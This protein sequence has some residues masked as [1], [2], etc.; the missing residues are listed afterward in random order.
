MNNA[1]QQY[2]EIAKRKRAE[3][4]P[5][6]LKMPSGAVWKIIPLDPTSLALSGKLPLR[7]ALSGRK[8]LNQ[9][10]N[11]E[12]MGAQLAEKLSGDDVISILELT[13]DLILTNLL[14]PKVTLE[15]TEDS[16]TPGMILP[17]DFNY[18]MMHVIS[19]GAANNQSPPAPNF[20]PGAGNPTT[21]ENAT[22]QAP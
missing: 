1:K 5:V 14:E 15:E 9:P 4:P 12:E 22:D 6:E 16:I 19:A 17:E 8:N 13:R 21:G 20:Y 2:L 7:A 18:F 10:L 3:Q 11:A